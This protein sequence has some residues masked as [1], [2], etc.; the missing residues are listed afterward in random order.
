[1]M[2]GVKQVRQSN[3]ELLRIFAMLC[4]VVHHLVIFGVAGVGYGDRLELSGRGIFGALINAF[5][6]CGVDWFVLI[7]GWFG[8]RRGWL[9]SVRLV[10]EC[11]VF[12]AIAWAGS[13]LTMNGGGHGLLPSLWFG[14]YWFVT[15]YIMMALCAPFLEVALLHIGNCE[16]MLC[17]A[18]F[19]V[20]N[21]IFGWGFGVVTPR[22]YDFVNFMYLY[23]LG[24]LLRRM[25]EVDFMWCKRRGVEIMMFIGGGLVLFG[26]WVLINRFGLAVDA[27][28]WFACNSPI[29]LMMSV[30]GLMLFANVRF[31]S[32]VVNF[33]AGG[34]F[35]VY[36]LH[37]A[38]CVK[39]FR[40]NLA[41]AIYD[42]FSWPGILLLAI[43]I[44]FGGMLISTL[45]EL[46]VV[47]PMFKI[48]RR[49]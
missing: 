18:G 13:A 30:A 4:I 11:A 37:C 14:N 26:G 16:L 31:H 24:R 40:N 9:V 39:A 25:G 3:F 12:G 28:R 32:R 48:F 41:M 10:I 47:K 34:T 38:P 17:I 36:I 35:G 27:R 42:K 8:V 7:S 5:V 43:V 44:V 2:S 22:G 49:R 45:V 33:L 6:I 46:A 1:M 20:V 29:V 15:A 21:V 19:T 23:V